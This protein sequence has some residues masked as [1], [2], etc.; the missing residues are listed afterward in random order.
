M[1]ARATTSRR[2]TTTSGHDRARQKG[3]MLAHEWGLAAVR[4]LHLLHD[5]CE[6]GMI[7]CCCCVPFY[8]PDSRVP[9]LLSLLRRWRCARGDAAASA[10]RASGQTDGR[11]S[12]D[13]AVP[14][15]VDA[16]DPC[17]AEAGAERARTNRDIAA[18]GGG[19]SLA[20]PPACM[21]NSVAPKA[22][23]RRRSSTRRAA[24]AGWVTRACPGAGR[25]P[26]ASGRGSMGAAAPEVELRV[27]DDAGR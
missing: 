3:C 25:P 24:V 4:R 7:G 19:L 5:P 20:C 8:Y 14:D 16:G 6:P 21:A 9:L 15:R 17:C 26:T 12:G 1:L 22:L 18:A 11:P 27:V 13:P 23:A 10:R 2:S